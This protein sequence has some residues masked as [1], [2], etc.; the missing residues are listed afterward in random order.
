MKL[1]E[2]DLDA[3]YR[4]AR[5]VLAD[6]AR[7]GL[8]PVDGQDQL[9][10]LL[11]ERF[12]GRAPAQGR[13]AVETSPTAMTIHA[14]T[15]ASVATPVPMNIVAPIT[16]AVARPASRRWLWA[17]VVAIVAVAVAGVVITQVTA[18][19]PATSAI[20]PVP[21]ASAAP[22]IATP[23]TGSDAGIEAGID[24]G[25]ETGNNVR[26]TDA[27]VSDPGSAAPPPR[28]KPS[29][30]ARRQPKGMKS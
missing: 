23:D 20:S 26:G 11:A 15:P 25:N 27:A 12:V 13:R 8:V 5:S 9:A 1:L 19:Q 4:D 29:K 16:Y 14:G 21:D 2:R 18:E 3:R 6:L 22:P 24:A 10:A 30:P 7:T 28:R 17:A